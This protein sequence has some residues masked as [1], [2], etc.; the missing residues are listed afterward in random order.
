MPE[1]TIQIPQ[2]KKRTY[3]PDNFQLTN[4]ESIQPFYENLKNREIQSDKDLYQWFEDRSE[5]EAYLSENFAWRYI[6]MTCDT[7]NE[8]LVNQLQDFITNIQPKIAPE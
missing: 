7:N 3:L 4:W 1:T 8:Q 5:L 2:R 6:Q